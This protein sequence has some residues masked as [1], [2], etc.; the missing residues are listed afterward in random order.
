MKANAGLTNEFES[1]NDERDVIAGNKDD[2][3]HEML[4]AG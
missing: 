4:I 3:V 2:E 1:N